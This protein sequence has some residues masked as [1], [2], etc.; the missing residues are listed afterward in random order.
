MENQT[1]KHINLKLLKN[2]K[3]SKKIRKIRAKINFKGNISWNI[4]VMLILDIWR[5]N[6]QILKKGSWKMRK[7]IIK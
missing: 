5:Q 3:K 2:R 7:D 4:R 1:A 6:T